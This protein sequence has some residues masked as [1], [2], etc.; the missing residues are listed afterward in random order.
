RQEVSFV[1]TVSEL[2]RGE[3]IGLNVDQDAGI[4]VGAGLGE[5]LL[6]PGDVHGIAGLVLGRRRVA[7]CPATVRLFVALLVGH[8]KIVVAANNIQGDELDV[9]VLEAAILAVGLTQR[10]LAPTAIG[11]AP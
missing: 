8:D 2:D 3:D 1:A 11:S 4:M 7:V 5:G 10:A 9:V 6:E